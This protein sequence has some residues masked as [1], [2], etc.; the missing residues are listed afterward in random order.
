M[1]WYNNPVLEEPEEDMS[2]HAT[3]MKKVANKTLLGQNVKRGV[4][5]HEFDDERYGKRW[6]DFVAR[7]RHPTYE[8]QLPVQIEKEMKED[9]NTRNLPKHE[10]ERKMVEKFRE[11]LQ[12]ESWRDIESQSGPLLQ[13]PREL[14]EGNITI[15]DDMLGGK[16]EHVEKGAVKRNELAKRSELAKK[17][18]ERDVKLEKEVGRVMKK[19]PLIGN[20]SDKNTAP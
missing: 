14:A 16:E 18:E 7:R 3:A 9:Q 20:R 5:G 19:K 17:E 6:R 13:N 1:S 2:P 15:G 4:Y 8:K 11:H 10:K 12:P